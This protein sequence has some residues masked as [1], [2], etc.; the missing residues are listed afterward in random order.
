LYV[1]LV[2]ALNSL[3]KGNGAEAVAALEPA[4]RFDLSTD[5]FAFAYAALYV[6]GLAYLKMKDGEKAAAELQKILD[7]PGRGTVSTLRPMAQ[8]QMARAQAM[9]GDT[10]K[11]KAEYQDFL[12][13]WKD[14]DADVPA[15]VEA[16]AEYG[17]MK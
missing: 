13:T 4:R 2:K 1:P 14:A 9:K 10:G 7:N 6:R 11:A 12:A 17:K 5:P 16:K 15:L 8:L 3:Q